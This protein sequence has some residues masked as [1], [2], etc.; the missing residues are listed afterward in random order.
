MGAERRLRLKAIS[1]KP[2]QRI[3]LITEDT[4]NAFEEERFSSNRFCGRGGRTRFSKRPHVR[5]VNDC[6]WP[7]TIA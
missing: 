1:E 5:T 6:L 7:P 2:R 3:T 4:L